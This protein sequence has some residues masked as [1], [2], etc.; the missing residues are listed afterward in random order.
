ML[1]RNFATKIETNQ[2]LKKKE[3]MGNSLQ[4]FQSTVNMTEEIEAGVVVITIAKYQ[5]ITNKNMVRQMM[6]GWC[7]GTT[8]GNLS[9]T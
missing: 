1:Q 6:P 2:I 3:N 9:S 7:L 5:Q 8:N 4:N